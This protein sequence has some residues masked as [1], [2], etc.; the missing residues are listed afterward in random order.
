MPEK[1]EIYVRDATTF[2]HVLQ[3]DY[4]VSDRADTILT[5]ILTLKRCRDGSR[6][7]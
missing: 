4:A 6:T 5:T 3:G 2:V 1:S 7:H